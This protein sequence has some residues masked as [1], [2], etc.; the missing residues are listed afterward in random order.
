MQMLTEVV[1][2]KVN[3]EFEFIRDSSGQIVKTMKRRDSDIKETI[4][5]TDEKGTKVYNEIDG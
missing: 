1:H 4:V 3:Q 2:Q 5:T